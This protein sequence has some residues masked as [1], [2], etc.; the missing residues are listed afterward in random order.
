MK[1]TVAKFL[2][3]C[4]CAACL[5]ACGSSLPDCDSKEVIQLLKQI[6]KEQTN[7]PFANESVIE[8][9]KVSAVRTIERNDKSCSC[10]AIGTFAALGETMDQRFTYS[11]EMADNGDEFMVTIFDE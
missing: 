11:V 5:C 3:C 10:A 1:K 6:V 9:K 8:L 7:L 2:A 4:L